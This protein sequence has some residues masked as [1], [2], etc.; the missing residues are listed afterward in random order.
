MIELKFGE[1]REG[2][3]GGGVWLVLEV[4]KGITWLW[5]RV[6]YSDGGGRVLVSLFVFG[7]GLGSRVQ[8]WH[9]C[10]C[11]VQLLKVIFLI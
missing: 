11:E 3:G 6:K 9:D 2:G 10:W 1:K 5:F 8:F 7:I 4:G